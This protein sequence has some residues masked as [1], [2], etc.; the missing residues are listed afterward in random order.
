VDVCVDEA[1]Q[2]RG[3][4]KGEPGNAGLEWFYRELKEAGL[5]DEPLEQSL[6]LRPRLRRVKTPPARRTA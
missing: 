6:T 3:L 2:Q 1:G 5:D 4:G